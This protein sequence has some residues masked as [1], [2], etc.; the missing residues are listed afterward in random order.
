MVQ[1]VK[2]GGRLPEVYL[3][4]DGNWGGTKQDEA[5]MEFLRDIV[6]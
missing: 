1:E 4:N 2:A 5:F 6:G 3:A